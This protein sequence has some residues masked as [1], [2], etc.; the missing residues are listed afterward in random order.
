MI[1]KKF[2]IIINLLF[3]KKISLRSPIQHDFV[4]FDIKSLNDVKSFFDKYDYFIL[5]TRINILK[6]IYLSP[7]VI[8]GIIK[9]FHSGNIFTVYLLSLLE[10]IKPKVVITKID[11]SFKFSELARICEKKYTF[12]GIQLLEICFLKLEIDTDLLI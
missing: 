11:N 12:V 5:E 8:F 3:T 10:I 6:K 1:L 7:S 9:N 4:V 2:F